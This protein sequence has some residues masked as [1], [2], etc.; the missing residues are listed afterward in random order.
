MILIIRLVLPICV[1][2]GFGC[3]VWG[4]TADPRIHRIYVAFACASV[5]LAYETFF[6][7][8]CGLGEGRSEL[9]QARC[10][11]GTPFLP[12]FG[13]PALALIAVG[14]SRSKSGSYLLAG[15]AI[16]LV[17]FIVPWALIVQA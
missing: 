12:L 7:Q 16:F 3:L 4:K 1:A 2:I 17:S 8:L 13:V 15:V 11:G 10:S 14:A 9:Y 6:L 5:I